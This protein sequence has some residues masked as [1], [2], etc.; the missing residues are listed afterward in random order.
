MSFEV[1]NVSKEESMTAE[2]KQRYFEQLCEMDKEVLFRLFENSDVYAKLQE[3]TKKCAAAR[4][5]RQDKDDQND[6]ISRRDVRDN[7]GETELFAY[8]TDDDVREHGLCVD[9]NGEFYFTEEQGR[10]AGVMYVL[11]RRY[12]NGF[13]GSVEDEPT[14]RYT[15]VNDK[16][17]LKIY[18]GNMVKVT[19]KNDEEDI[20]IIEFRD[21]AFGVKFNRLFSKIHHHFLPLHSLIHFYDAY[22]EVL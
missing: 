3:F 13:S 6:L 16:N 12:I 21:G 15:G 8:L 9:E 2:E 14:E 7:I 18:N 10:M 4:T 22:F 20:G 11:M 17:E 19:L 1:K 5:I